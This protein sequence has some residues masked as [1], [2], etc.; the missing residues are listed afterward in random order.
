MA[1]I[2]SSAAASSAREAPFPFPSPFLPP[3]LQ[4]P[5]SNEYKRKPLL[6][7]L[8]FSLFRT[9]PVSRV[10]SR[11]SARATGVAI[12]SRL[13]YRRVL[14][15]GGP[16]HFIPASS[17]C[18]GA[19]ELITSK[20]RPGLNFNQALCVLSSNGGAIFYFVYTSLFGSSFPFGTY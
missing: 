18:V 6:P 4:P 1:L 7:A 3:V 15:S 5:C 12:G 11:D 20:G 10:I 19:D 8:L 9:D 16:I 17:L 13:N 14:S 2:T